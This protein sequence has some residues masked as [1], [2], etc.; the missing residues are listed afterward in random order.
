LK[1]GLGKKYWKE[2]D[3]IEKNL[4]KVDEEIIKLQYPVPKLISKETKSLKKSQA[5]RVPE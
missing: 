5:T 2:A 3:K 1:K 4:N